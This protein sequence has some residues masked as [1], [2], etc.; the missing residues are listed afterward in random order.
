M[1]FHAACADSNRHVYHASRI[2]Y[3]CK[4]NGPQISDLLITIL[5]GV[6]SPRRSTLDGAFHG[7]GCH[8]DWFDASI[9]HDPEFVEW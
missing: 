7:P 1:L 4:C 3:F 6:D 8:W 5:K 9:Q 2:V